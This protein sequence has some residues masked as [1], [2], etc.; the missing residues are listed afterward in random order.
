MQ[1]GV[2]SENFS[3]VFRIIYINEKNTRASPQ[4]MRNILYVRNGKSNS[5]VQMKH[6]AKPMHELKIENKIISEYRMQLD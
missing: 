5:S 1:I 6:K 4:L 3:V 2:L